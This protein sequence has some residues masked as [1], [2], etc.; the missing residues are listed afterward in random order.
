MRGDYLVAMCCLVLT[1]SFSGCGDDAAGPAGGSTATKA[2]H[3]HAEEGPHGG[4]IIELGGEDYHAELVHNDATHKV[5]VYLLD[6]TAKAA[7]PINAAS[8]AINSRTSGEPKQFTL[9]ASP[10]PGEP[11]GSSS[12]FELVSEELCTALDD[13]DTASRLS[14]TI[15]D[16]PYVG[17]IE[18]HGHD[19]GHDHEHE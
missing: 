1:A 10:Q 19:H 16:K 5:G 12:Y 13:H 8:L 18:A 4:K 6:G 9:L 17:V 15:D 3:E 2:D 11:E 7:A 14:V